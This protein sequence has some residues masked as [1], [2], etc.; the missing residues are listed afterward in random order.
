MYFTINQLTRKTTNATVDRN[1][2]DKRLPSAS[3]PTIIDP[4]LKAEVVFRG[5]AYPTD[6]AFLGN[7][8]IL[9]IEKDTGIVKK[10]SK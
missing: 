5:L 1:Y 8:D 3:G 10:N 9:V 2:P 7:N 6:I 4:N